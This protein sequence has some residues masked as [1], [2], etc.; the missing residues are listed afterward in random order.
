MKKQ[1]LLLCM[2]ILLLHACGY[3]SAVPLDGIQGKINRNLLGAWKGE[4]TGDEFTL[5]AQNEFIYKL[6]IRKKLDTEIS[7]M[8]GYLT[9]FEGVIFLNA[10]DTLPS[11]EPVKYSF[12]RIEEITNDKVVVY[13]VTENISEQFSS[14]QA[15]RNFFRNNMKNSYF[16][17]PAVICQR[18]NPQK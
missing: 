11:S 9:G 13:P 16:Y 17:E 14:S 10:W 1:C 7:V 3:E 5:T 6:R 12:F 4:N 18:L 15:L 2:L 8:Y